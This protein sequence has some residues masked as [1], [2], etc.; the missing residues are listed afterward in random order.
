M[1]LIF[2][3]GSLM[4][5]ESAEKTLKRSLTANDLCPAMIQN[6]LR[7]WTAKADVKLLL[8]KGPR[9]CDALFLDLTEIPG[10]SCNGVAINVTDEEL[11]YLDTRE[12]GYERC[13]VELILETSAHVKAFAYR[14]P[15]AD[16]EHYGI[17]L[18]KYHRVIE[19][20]LKE[21]PAAFVEQFWDTTLASEAMLVEGDYIFE[22][23]AQNA[24]AGHCFSVV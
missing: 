9:P 23:C 4:N 3:Y 18:A 14:V 8:D 5:R 15:L 21:F 20:A 11:L 2:G 10:T 17:T 12:C 1:P 7:S 16:K 13:E 24:A 19:D 6:H 22:D